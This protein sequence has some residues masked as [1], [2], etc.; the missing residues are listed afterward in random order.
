MRAAL[1]GTLALLITGSCLAQQPVDLSRLPEPKDFKALRSS[2]NNPDKESNDD[3][4]RPIPGETITLAE[5]TGPGAVTHIWLTVAANEY[6]GLGSCDCGFTTTAARC[7][8]STR[9]SATSSRSGTASSDL[10][11][12]S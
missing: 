8:R 1:A 6:A 11:S 9:P 10:S 4:K 2:S 5:L 7:L 12:R 3:S